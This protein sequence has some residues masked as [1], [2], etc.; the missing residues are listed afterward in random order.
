M[1]IFLL[2]IIALVHSA[3]VKCSGTPYTDY[4][5]N[6]VGNIPSA[7]FVMSTAL[8]YSDPCEKI[9][10][11]QMRKKY[12]WITNEH[13]IEHIIDTKNGPSELESCDKDIRGNKVVAN[14]G[15]NRAVGQKCWAQVSIEK[16]IVYSEA[17]I[18]AYNSVKRCC[19]KQPDIN[20][21][22]V[23]PAV[24]LVLSLL[25]VLISI[26]F[27]VKRSRERVPNDTGIDMESDMDETEITMH[28]L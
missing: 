19:A 12:S 11:S 18:K 4:Y 20:L 8:D 6:N 22:N 9:T 3:A 15:W 17:F 16:E 28:K 23:L 21:S 1:L 25:V 26:I 27:F 7:F 10:N 5:K 2:L 24:M 13:D 14:A